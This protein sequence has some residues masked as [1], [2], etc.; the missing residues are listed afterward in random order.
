M[1]VLVWHES[2]SGALIGCKTDWTISEL[3]QLILYL[4]T[5]L[6]DYCYVIIV[7]TGNITA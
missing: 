1:H 2:A 4:F 7:D 6:V 3:I 5:Y